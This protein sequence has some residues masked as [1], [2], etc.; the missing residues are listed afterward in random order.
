MSP[1]L[2]K[3]IT[4]GHFLKMPE[5]FMHRE[6]PMN[7]LLIWV[8]GGRG[9][10]DSA[11]HRIEARPGH[12]LTY[13]PGT[14]HTYG[15]D[16]KEPWDI[17]W[18]HFEG[19]LAPDLFGEIRRLGGE[20][21]DLGFDAE[22]RDR[23]I[24]LVIAHA[25]R[26]PAWEWRVNPALYALL[27]AIIHRLHRRA[28]KPPPEPPFDVHRLRAYIHHHLA[29][30]ITLDVL[31]RQV[32][33]STPHFC[34]LFKQQFAVSPIYYVL[35]ERVALASALLTETTLPLKQISE[36]VGYDDPYYF[37]R[38]F[39]KMTGRSPTAY[40]AAQREAPPGLALRD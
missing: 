4:S 36:S 1:D 29:E 20:N 11:G 8:L 30:P 32:N 7:Y 33:L 6:A 19:T 27:G 14:P 16:K 38:L 34:R 35:Q 13:P 31:A 3:I 28:A 15:S 9:Y 18:V 21:V 24:E 40:R 23:W 5:H 2:V 37:S 10:S 25:A 17:V 22:I 39:K 26:G 12:L